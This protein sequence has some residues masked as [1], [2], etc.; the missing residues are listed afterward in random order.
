MLDVID[1]M[2]LLFMIKMRY[3]GFESLVTIRMLGLGKLVYQS[4]PR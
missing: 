1:E 4:D 3:R 2:A